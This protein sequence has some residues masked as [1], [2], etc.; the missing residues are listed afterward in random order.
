MKRILKGIVFPLWLLAGLSLLLFKAVSNLSA[1]AIGLAML[2]GLGLGAYAVLTLRW[3]DALIFA[4][5]EGFLLLIQAAEV[6]VELL[7]EAV[8]DRLGR[9]VQA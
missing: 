6:S 4:G 7:L 8:R 2:I 9:I 1:Y 5:I 3:M